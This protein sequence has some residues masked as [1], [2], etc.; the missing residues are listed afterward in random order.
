MISSYSVLAVCRL[1]TI[2]ITI[3][4]VIVGIIIH[5]RHRHPSQICR[6][7][8]S[9]PEDRSTTETTTSGHSMESSSA[10]TPAIRLEEVSAPTP[11][12]FA[13]RSAD[14]P[15]IRLE[16]VS[17]GTFE[18]SPALAQLPSSS[19]DIPAIRLMEVSP[20]TFEVSPALAPMP[21]TWAPC[22]EDDSDNKDKDFDVHMVSG[23]ADSYLKQIN[24]VWGK[25]KNV[26]I[27]ASM[28]Q[29][30][31]MKRKKR[32]YWKDTKPGEQDTQPGEQ[33]GERDTQPG[34][35]GER[36]TQPGEP[37]EQKEEKDTQPGERDTQP[38]EQD[39]KPGEQ[40]T[41]PRQLQRTTSHEGEQ[42][43]QGFLQA[44]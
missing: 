5:R 19:A 43:T 30:Y 24:R 21:G 44:L 37:G 20:G 28:H 29:Y 27:L 34:E 13:S 4:N 3:T 11:Q 22:Q 12:P 32:K 26:F 8:G 38:G 33:P 7:L 31:D 25:P 16:E 39:T 23:C 36:G 2:T 15:A 1:T 14:T 6:Q 40:G 41:T 35:P 9:R 18:V 42:G 10:D 17:A